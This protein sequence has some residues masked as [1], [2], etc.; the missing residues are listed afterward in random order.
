MLFGVFSM[1]LHLS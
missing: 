1:N